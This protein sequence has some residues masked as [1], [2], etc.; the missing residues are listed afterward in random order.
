MVRVLAFLLL[1][2][3]VVACTPY[4]DNAP[5]DVVAQV[6]YRHDGPPKITLFT[7]I[8]NRT[9]AGAHSSLM[10]NASQRVVFDPAGS[11]RHP[12]IAERD[13]VLFGI[14]PAVAEFYESAHARITYH[15]VIQEIEVAPEVAERALQLALARGRVAGGF[16][17]QATSG[18]LTQLPGFESI[19]PSFFPNN[20]MS[21]FARIPGVTERKL[22]EDDDD[23]KGIAVR[24]FEIPAAIAGIE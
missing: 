22:F 11:V 21:Q 5:D 6:A 12:R 18:I 7:M 1:P 23:D 3:L 17:S 14:T 10:I 20:T 16:C 24:A 4:S 15:V 8:N 13:D 2:F 9:G 19:R